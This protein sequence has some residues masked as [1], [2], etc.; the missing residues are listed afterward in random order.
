MY[1][2]CCSR[3]ATGVLARNGIHRLNIQYIL[4]TENTNPPYPPLRVSWCPHH[5]Y[6]SG[7]SVKATIS[8]KN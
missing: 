2:V 8:V 3:F 5:A 4:D 6:G 7:A 1:I